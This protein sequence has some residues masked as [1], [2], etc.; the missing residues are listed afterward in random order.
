MEIAPVIY[1]STCAVL[2]CSVLLLLVGFGYWSLTYN[3]LTRRRNIAKQSFSGIDIQL[4]KRWDLIPQLV[5]TVKAHTESEAEVLAQISKVRNNAVANAEYN[6]L[7]SRAMLE[8]SLSN[9][10]LVLLAIAES[11]P[12]LQVSEQ[13]EILQRNLTEAESQISAARRAYNAAVLRYNNLIQSFPSNL[14]AKSHGFK[15][16]DFFSAEDNE[17][18]NVRV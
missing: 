10:A 12:S 5:E 8:D 4:K 9:S 16:M 17:R 15:A 1:A 6:D 3:G 14:I 18:N 2:R 11:Y 7:R 13:Y